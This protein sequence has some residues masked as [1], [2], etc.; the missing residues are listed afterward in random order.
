VTRI[1]IVDDQAMVRTGFR[2]IL[3]SEEDIDVA[4]EAAD[5]AEAID[6]ARELQPDVIL[7]DIRMPKLDGLEATRRILAG[8]APNAKV[9]VLTTFDLDEY[10]YESL[11]AGA[12]GFMLKDA[13]PEQLVEAIRIVAS[14]DSLLAPS[15]TRRVIEGFVQGRPSRDG[16]PPELESLTARELEVLQALARGCSNAE[17]AKELFVSE[18]TVKTHVARVLQ[19][20][21]LRDRVQAVVLAYESGLVQPGSA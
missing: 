17:I 9:L 5:G 14:G 7:M 8:A 21:N 18:T 15:V 3:E 2:M 10:V 12:S 13:P 6:R 4:G 19:K 1:L 11:R 20:L 16:P